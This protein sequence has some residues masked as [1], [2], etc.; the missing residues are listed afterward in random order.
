VTDEDTLEALEVERLGQR[1]AAGET[2]V[3]VRS[4]ALAN[5]DR[6]LTSRLP[7]AVTGLKVEVIE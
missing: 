4:S 2:E 1:P 7:A 6:I 5:G 3:L